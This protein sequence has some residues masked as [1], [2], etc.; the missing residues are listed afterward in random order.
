MIENK[1]SYTGAELQEKF[2][3]ASSLR[4]IISSLEVSW[5]HQGKVISAV[6]VNGMPL[7][8][9]DEARLATT[10]IKEIM[11][12]EL[13]VESPL[14]LFVATLETQ[15]QLIAELER[16]SLSVATMFRDLDVGRGH[17]LMI[18]LL[19][20]SRWFV[21]AL[22]SIKESIGTIIDCRFDRLTWEKNEND[23]RST[24]DQALVA[25]ERLDYILL[26]DILEFD[27]SMSIR[28]W[29][30]VLKGL[31]HQAQNLANNDHHGA[32][33]SCSES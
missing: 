18:A 1:V 8:E 10:A 2:S 26:A 19:D 6:S 9:S 21:D 22:V 15:L 24:I 4:E 7:T 5:R 14:N 23:F 31:A 33:K 29:E 20:S 30:S 11:Q 17:S 25:M 13:Q 32:D 12:I 3:P 16:V 28:S 27:Y